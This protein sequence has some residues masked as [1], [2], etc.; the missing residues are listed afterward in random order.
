MCDVPLDLQRRFEQRWASRFAR[1]NPQITPKKHE[2]EREDL[3]QL[4]EVIPARQNRPWELPV[5]LGRRLP[6]SIG[7]SLAVA[8]RCWFPWTSPGQARRVLTERSGPLCW[9]PL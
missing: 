9:R 1:P 8:L 4:S 7:S 3:D 5:R 2:R 6:S